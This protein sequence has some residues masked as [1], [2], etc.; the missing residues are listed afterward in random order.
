MK[1][2]TQ[3]GDSVDSNFAKKLKN[4]ANAENKE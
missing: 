1:R 4:Y 2:L 3:S